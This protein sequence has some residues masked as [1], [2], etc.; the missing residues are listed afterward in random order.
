MKSL[1]I[2]L[3]AALLGPTIGVGVFLLAN[4]DRISGETALPIQA[5]GPVPD[6]DQAGVRTFAQPSL[7]LGLK[8]SGGLEPSA[9]TPAAH[10]SPKLAAWLTVVRCPEGEPLP[11]TGNCS[12]PA[13]PT[14]VVTSTANNDGAS[15][16]AIP[17]RVP[18]PL[19][20]RMSLS[21]SP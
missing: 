10:A 16:I 3:G 21:K 9:Q 12:A 2:S 17:E 13:W 1:A 15:K 11:Q 20:G 7:W 4:G 14:A 6:F 5:A 18:Y 8:P 19:P